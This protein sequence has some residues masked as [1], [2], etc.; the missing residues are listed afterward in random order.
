MTS[1]TLQIWFGTMMLV[2]LS[3][4]MS[5]PVSAQNAR[6]TSNLLPNPLFEE[7]SQGGVRGWKSR[8]WSGGQNDWTVKSPG[9][10]G[11]RCLAIKSEQGSDAAWTTT[12]TVPSNAFYRLS[13]WIKTKS[14]RGAVGAL[15]NI[16]NLQQ[17][18]TPPVTGTKDWSH[19]STGFRTG[20]TTELEI[21]CRFG[22]WGQSTAHAE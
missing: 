1:N 21:N 13:G 22:G 15:L 8:A 5:Q 12:V 11:Q 7:S 19:V 17:V 10:T 2:G 20:T 18:R 9:R 6:V 16:Q 4:L 14:L 3:A